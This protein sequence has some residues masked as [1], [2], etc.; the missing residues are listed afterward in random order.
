MRKGQFEPSPT[1]A[2]PQDQPPNGLERLL[3]RPVPL[4]L[5][6]AIFF[7]MAALGL[8]Y[9]ALILHV[10]RGGTAPGWLQRP[11]LAAAA[12][13]SLLWSLPERARNPFLSP[14]DAPGPPPARPGLTRY[15]FSD[16]GFL[17]APS[18]DPER[19]RPLVRLIRL[20]DGAVVREYAPDVRPL[21]AEA[22]RLSTPATDVRGVPFWI[23][24]PE[25]LDDGSILFKGNNLLVRLDACNRVAWTRFGFH[26][27]IE[28]AAEGQF[29]IAMVHRT[30][31]RRGAGPAYR[32]EAI[33]LV[34]EDGEILRSETLDEIFARNGLAPLVHG[35]EYSNDP[36]HLNDIEP[37]LEDG[38]YWKRGD[39]F[40]S[41]AHQSMILLYRPS[42]G[43]ILWRRTGPWMVQHDVNI[44]DDRRIA[45]F[46]NRVSLDAAG[47]VVIGNSREL[48]VDFA[49]GTIS[50]PWET[51]FRRLAVRASSNG[52]GTVLS[53]GDIVIEESMSGEAMRVN[54]RGDVRW[55]YLNT[56]QAGRRYRLFWSRYL[57]PARYARGVAAATT[58]RC[59]RA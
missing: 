15:G 55:R 14:P 2:K 24:H 32:S 53:G 18:Y 45:I 52:R 58:A 7:L 41:L 19:R 33:A 43:R 44:L 3:Y 28:R 12:S 50:S 42:T 56:D 49:T 10:T 30:P 29:W 16:P 37:V 11:A 26:H 27:S 13:T 5:P 47:P 20:R 36:Y 8:A 9:G 23:G 46:D 6:L 40:L 59:G 1:G 48:V 34:S 57:D 21:Q 51:A 31:M 4:W 22:E 54:A 39:L 38:R 17:L 25:L 35:R